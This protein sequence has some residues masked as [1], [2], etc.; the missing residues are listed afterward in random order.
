MP[1]RTIADIQERAKTLISLWD[2]R[3][4]A[5]AHNRD[6]F[7]LEHY[8]K[9]GKSQGAVDTPNAAGTA[10]SI[11]SPSSGGAGTGT[12]T[13]LD[14]NGAYRVTSSEYT[15]FTLNSAFNGDGPS[16]P[17]FAATPTR[18]ARPVTSAARTPKSSS[19]RYVT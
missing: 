16:S 7:A 5:I 11:G 1:R 4:Q 18:R 19:W 2:G 13:N 10:V 6:L 14:S 17:S 12:R 9:G 15:D 3:N 8:G